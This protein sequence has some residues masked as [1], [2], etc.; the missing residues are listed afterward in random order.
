MHSPVARI[1]LAP[2]RSTSTPIGAW[3]TRV[4]PGSAA[5][6]AGLQPDD[7]VVNYNGFNIKDGRAFA[8]HAATAVVGQ[9]VTLTVWRAGKRKA[10]A[11]VPK[12]PG[13]TSTASSET[14]EPN[15]PAARRPIRPRGTVVDLGGDE[16]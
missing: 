9:P 6:D 10:F 14:K 3:V 8:V 12:A 13:A 7:V 16:A 4:K 5:S 2:K 11:V 1:F 15:E